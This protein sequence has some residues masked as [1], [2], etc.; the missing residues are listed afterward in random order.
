ML[1]DCQPKHWWQLPKHTFPAWKEIGRWK[2]TSTFDGSE[3]GII[4]R[5]ERKCVFCGELEIKSIRY[6]D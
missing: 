2:L 1:S 6:F 4:V 3:L 5:F